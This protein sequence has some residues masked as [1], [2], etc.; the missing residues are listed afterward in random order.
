MSL[1]DSIKR[2]FGSAP[3]ESEPATSTPE[4]PATKGIDEDPVISSGSGPVEVDLD[5]GESKPEPTT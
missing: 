1:I 3:S 4:P 5:E 2:L